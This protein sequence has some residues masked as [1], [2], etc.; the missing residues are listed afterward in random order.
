MVSTSTDRWR[1][2]W[3]APEVDSLAAAT[4]RA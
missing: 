3:Q 2:R 4:R 1:W